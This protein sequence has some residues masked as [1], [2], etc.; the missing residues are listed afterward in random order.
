VASLVLRISRPAGGEQDQK[1]VVSE[2]L[3]GG[4]PHA[5][6]YQPVQAAGK[7]ALQVPTCLCL[8]AALTTGWQCGIVAG[9]GWVEYLLPT[10]TTLQPVLCQAG[11]LQLC[12]W[13]CGAA[14]IITE[15]SCISGAPTHGWGVCSSTAGLARATSDH[16]FNATIWDVL[17]DPEYQGQGLGKAL[18]E[19]MVGELQT[20]DPRL[21]PRH[22]PR[23]F[24]ALVALRHCCVNVGCPAQLHQVINNCIWLPA[25]THP[26]AAGHLQHHP[27]C[28]LQG[29]G[30][31]QAA[32]F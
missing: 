30:L 32:R 31:L 10:I 25:G 23:R 6:R 28:R 15:L 4:T 19:Q 17:V 9:S 3:I 12:T 14:C 26:V 20:C 22:C 16:A 7:P 24:D 8:M 18:V 11:M 2:T 29:G 21:C 5:C 13:P 1:E 27:L